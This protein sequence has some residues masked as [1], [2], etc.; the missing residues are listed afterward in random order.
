MS[1]VV[2]G[3]KEMLAYFLKPSLPRSLP[4]LT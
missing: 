1:Q 2:Y 4:N 3:V